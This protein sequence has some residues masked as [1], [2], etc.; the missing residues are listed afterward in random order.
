VWQW[1][2]AADKLLD[3]ALLVEYEISTITRHHISRIVFFILLELAEFGWD[4]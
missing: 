1:T 2:I 4:K 3:I